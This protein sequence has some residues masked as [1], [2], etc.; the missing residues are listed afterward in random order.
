M[1]LP[2]VRWA[3]SNYFNEGSPL[4][5]DL[6]DVP[7][8]QLRKNTEAPVNKRTARQILAAALRGGLSKQYNDLIRSDPAEFRG[9]RSSGPTGPT[10]ER[11]KFLGQMYSLANPALKDAPETKDIRN[12]YRETLGQTEESLDE[13]FDNYNGPTI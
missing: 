2:S 10:Y 12:L 9:P 8:S 5:A 13:E 7:G 3:G 1:A 11:A 4:T 6:E